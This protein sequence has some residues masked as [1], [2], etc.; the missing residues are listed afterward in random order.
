MSDQKIE[1]YIIPAVPMPLILPL[2]C[3]AEITA[4]PAVESLNSPAESWMKGHVNWRNQR[5]PVLSFSSLQD[6]S[7]D[8][9]RKKKPHLVVLNP[10]PNAT[11]K[12]YSGMLCYGDI[13]KVIV[14][15]DLSFAHLDEDI[16][17][18]YIDGIVEM[19]SEKLIVPKLSALGDAY[20]KF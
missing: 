8:E 9:S 7:I 2:E 10:I 15:P 13:L 3:I 16:D 17:R 20:S 19:D 14:E 18:S 6:S 5:L 11:R 12:T 1:C 4:K